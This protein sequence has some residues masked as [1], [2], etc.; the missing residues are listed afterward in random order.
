MVFSQDQSA[1]GWRV[2]DIQETLIA[3]ILSVVSSVSFVS[4]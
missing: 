2:F 1:V 4:L 3:A